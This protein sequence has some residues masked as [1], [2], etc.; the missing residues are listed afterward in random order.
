[1]KIVILTILICTFGFLN[2][3]D[4][5]KKAICKLTEDKTSGV[6][7]EVTFE[8]TDNGIKVTGSISGLTAGEHGFHI[9]T[10]PR[11]TDCLSTGS[12]FNPENKNHGAE[13]ATERHTGDLGNITANA[14]GVADLSYTDKVISLDSTSAND[15]TGRACVVHEKPDDLGKGGNAESLKTGNAGARLA[16][17]TIVTISAKFIAISALVL[18]LSF[19]Y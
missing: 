10:D 15:I 13:D 5:V 17:G 8:Q 4:T 9:H 2:C 18:L 11:T 16:C 3:Q 19:I 1:M 14:S 6:S 7:G 12:H